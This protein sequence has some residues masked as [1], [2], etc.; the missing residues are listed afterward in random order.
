M[1]DLSNDQTESLFRQIE[2]QNNSS[3]MNMVHDELMA[4][5]YQ[6]LETDTETSLD[7][8]KETENFINSFNYHVD[9]IYSQIES[10]FIRLSDI[11]DSIEKHLF[12]D[13][14]M[15][16]RYRDIRVM[17]NDFLSQISD[18]GKSWLDCINQ[19]KE[20]TPDITLLGICV[21]NVNTFHEEINDII[22]KG[23]Y[24]G[25]DITLKIALLIAPSISKDHQGLPHKAIIAAIT[26]MCRLLIIPNI[27]WNERLLRI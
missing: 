12:M 22:R 11:M 26:L 6:F 27:N 8:L 13:N 18:L 23:N 2:N 20:S 4:V 16:Y 19:S 21:H 10:C 15:K 3:L 7:S 17:N 25:R 24:S 1:A 5:Q 9:E 14:D